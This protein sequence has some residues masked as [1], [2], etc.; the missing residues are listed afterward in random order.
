MGFRVS[1]TGGLDVNTIKLFKGLDVEAFIAGRSLRDAED[2]KQAA[3]EFKQEI[4]RVFS[5]LNV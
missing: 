2:P 4:Q 1:V 3:I 5:W